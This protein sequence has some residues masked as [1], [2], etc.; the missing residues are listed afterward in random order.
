MLVTKEQSEL[1]KILGE[2][3]SHLHGGW[4]LNSN[5]ILDGWTEH[6]VV[7]FVKGPTNAQGSSGFFINTFQILPRHVSAYGCHPRGH[8]RLISYPSSVLCYGR[9][10]IMTLPVWPVVVE[11]V[12]VLIKNPLLPWAFGGLFTNHITLFCSPKSTCIFSCCLPRSS[13]HW[14]HSLVKWGAS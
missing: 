12:Q 11:C 3:R 4:S 9:V 10:Q 14:C 8:E 2:Q 13:R 1:Y 5:H 6:L 7:S